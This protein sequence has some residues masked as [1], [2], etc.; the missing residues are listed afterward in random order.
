MIQMIKNFNAK[1]IPLLVFLVLLMLLIQSIP[2]AVAE[3]QGEEEWEPIIDIRS[4]FPGQIIEAGDTAVFPITITNPKPRR[5][6][7]R[8]QYWAFG[9]AREWDIRFE[10]MGRNIHRLSIPP[11]ESRT[12]NVVVETPGDAPIGEHRI[13]VSF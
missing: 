2:V 12:V 13:D 1:R 8:I 6:D 4:D 7:H 9:E 3:G 10:A 11:R 5:I